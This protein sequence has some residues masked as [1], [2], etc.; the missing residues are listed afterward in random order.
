MT[1]NPRL[2]NYVASVD[3][4]RITYL[5][6][7][8]NEIHGPTG[9]LRC[10]S[11]CD[12]HVRESHADLE[13]GESYYEKLGSL[14]EG[15][16]VGGSYLREISE[17]LGD[18]P[19]AIPGAVA[20]EVGPGIS[21]YAST[22]IEL[23]YRYECLESSSFAVQ[24]MSKRFGLDLKETDA[25]SSEI[26]E[27]HYDLILAAHSIEHLVDAPRMLLRMAAALKPGGELWVVVPN[28]DDP[29][30]PG[31]IWF[32]N[33]VSLKSCLEACGLD[34]VAVASRRIIEREEF[35]YVRARRPLDTELPVRHHGRHGL[36][37]LTRE[38]LSKLISSL[39]HSGSFLEYGTAS[40]VTASLVADA[41]PGLHVVCVDNFA[42]ADAV[43][44]AGKEPARP[45][46][47][48]RNRRP[49]MSLWL[50]ELDSFARIGRGME[51]DA[52]LLD[53]P[54]DIESAAAAIEVAAPMLAVGGTIYVHDYADPNHAPVR[55]ATDAYAS[56][57]GL[58]VAWTC[59]C[60]AALIR[61]E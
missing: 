6:G 26:H 21:P 2:H 46:L 1:K 49:N 9:F 31:H 34:V 60:M 39:P 52:I 19:P 29:I 12:G 50:G 17:V 32:P 45:D 7:C 3:G 28:D 61:S 55:E 56:K 59:G 38:E 14:R 58:R 53:G 43:H 35:I 44:V 16:A 18:F 25:E 10:V 54:H 27:S 22:L 41:R 40:G 51:F 13:A 24:W 20:L 42:D 5:C 33:E 8:V 57:S 36:S 30:N 4:D 15:E 23:G 11:K 37:W 47:W 48:R